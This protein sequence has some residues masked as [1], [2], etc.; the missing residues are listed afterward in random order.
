MSQIFHGDS[1]SQS[2]KSTTTCIIVNSIQIN[3]SGSFVILKIC[4]CLSQTLGLIID[5]FLS[6]DSVRSFNINLSRTCTA[7]IIRER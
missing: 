6:L 5:T 4:S 2:S 7:L 3:I 1:H